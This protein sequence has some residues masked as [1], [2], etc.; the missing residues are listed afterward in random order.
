MQPLKLLV[1]EN[2][3]PALVLDLQQRGI[4]AVH[5][6]DRG[7]LEATDE[8]VFQKAYEED[9]IVVTANVRDFELLARSC[10][11][12]PGILLIETGNLSRDEQKTV[13]WQA[14]QAILTELST[15]SS[16]VNRVLRTGRDGHLLFENL[17]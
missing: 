4:D 6:R 5:I 10:E 16:M 12:H 17:P 1:D 2:L 13:V 15:G 8:E 3:S 7:L 14:T 9:R 11:I